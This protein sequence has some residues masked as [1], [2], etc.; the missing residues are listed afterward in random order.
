MERDLRARKQGHKRKSKRGTSI[1]LEIST[2]RVLPYT[3]SMP[4]KSRID[5]PGALH[6]IIIIISGI[7]RKRVFPDDVMG[8]ILGIGSA[9]F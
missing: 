5:G 1:K 6:H 9:V 8:T 7:E 4:R 2:T 3:D